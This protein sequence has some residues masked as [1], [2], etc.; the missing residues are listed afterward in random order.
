MKGNRISKKFE[1]SSSVALRRRMK[2]RLILAS[3]FLLCE[4]NLF[5]SEVLVSRTRFFGDLKIRDSSLQKIL[6]TYN[7]TQV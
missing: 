3:Y 7:A 4:S 1:P 5:S 6:V 2:E